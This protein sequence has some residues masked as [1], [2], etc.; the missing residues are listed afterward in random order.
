MNNQNF[1]ASGEYS[2]NYCEY[3]VERKNDS[4]LI[5]KK[6][7]IILASLAICVTVCFFI[8]NIMPQVLFIFVVCIGFCAMF[9]WR[10]V[11]IEY[12]YII[13][14]GEF[15]MD[16]IYG[17][18]S[19]KRIYSFKINEAHVI[20]PFNMDIVKSFENRT[21]YYTVSSKKSDTAYYALFKDAKGKSCAAVFD[22]TQKTLDI[23]KY[24]NRN[25]V[26]NDKTVI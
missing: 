5:F 16:A 15:D 14:S 2:Y 8:W 26:V 13:L 25:T 1:K 22:V 12:E 7:L 10:Y 11:S 20:A 19:R 9:A 23:L 24:Y 4:G 21:V 18:K 6:I 3:S 17:G